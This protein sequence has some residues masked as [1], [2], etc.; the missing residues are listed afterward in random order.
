MTREE[1]IKIIHDSGSSVTCPETMNCENLIETDLSETDSCWNCAEGILTEYEQ[2]L[3]KE[4]VSWCRKL[5]K[6]FWT[7]WNKS[8]HKKLS[9]L[10]Y[11]ELD[12]FILEQADESN[13]RE[14]MEGIK[15][16]VK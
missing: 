4:A 6:V 5:I 16:W 7:D 9:R 1:L 15:Q 10:A 14:F 12:E 3:R 2:E 8:S 13:G 11:D